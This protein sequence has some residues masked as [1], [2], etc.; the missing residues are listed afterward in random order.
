[1]QKAQLQKNFILPQIHK[2][3]TRNL[4]SAAGNQSSICLPNG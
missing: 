3:L 1:M 4:H 2:M